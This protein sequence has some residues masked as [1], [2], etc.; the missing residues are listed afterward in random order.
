M[1]GGRE[2]IWRQR[3]KGELVRRASM[4]EVGSEEEA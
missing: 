2:V 4:S 3:V 1:K